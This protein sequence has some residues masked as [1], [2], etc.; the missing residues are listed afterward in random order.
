MPLWDRSTFGRINSIRPLDYW[1]GWLI[2]LF[3][4]FF[5]CPSIVLLTITVKNKISW[6][7]Y[8]LY[9]LGNTEFGVLQNNLITLLK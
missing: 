4:L 8:I 3:L 2:V 9:V 6:V 5:I 1:D 7:I